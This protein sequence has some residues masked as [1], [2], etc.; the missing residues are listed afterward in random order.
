[1]HGR[2]ERGGGGGGVLKL[3]DL[4]SEELKEGQTNRLDATM[5]FFLLGWVRGGWRRGGHRW[6]E[7]EDCRDGR[8]FWGGGG[9]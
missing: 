7:R 3:V 4:L 1:M 9:G 8:R 2:G 6:G 5:A